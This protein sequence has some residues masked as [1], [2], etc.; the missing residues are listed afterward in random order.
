MAPKGKKFDRNN[1]D[2]DDYKDGKQMSALA[3]LLGLFFKRQNGSHSIYGNENGSMPIPMHG[4]YSRGM[5]KGMVKQ[6]LLLVG[7][8]LVVF[9]YIWNN[10]PP[11]IYDIFYH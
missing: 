3:V 5:R 8:A 9:V 4:E 10:C 7:G 1:I 11:F 2:P 6:M